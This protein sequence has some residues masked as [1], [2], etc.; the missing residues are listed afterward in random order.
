MILLC[1]VAGAMAQAP[2]FE[3]LGP[4]VSDR[5]TGLV[6]Q[7]CSVGMVWREGRCTG[8][9]QVF[10]WDEARGLGRDGWRLPEIDE[11]VS[12]VNREKSR[13]GEFPVTDVAAFPDLAGRRGDPLTYWSNTL[14]KGCMLGD[15][16]GFAVAFNVSFKGDLL[17]FTRKVP[18]FVRLVRNGARKAATASAPVKS[19]TADGRF[20][21]DGGVA[22]DRKTGL[23]WQRCL[24]GQ[25]WQAGRG[26]TGIR[27]RLTQDEAFAAE[28][29]GWRLPTKAELLTLID[30]D[31]KSAP[32][33]NAEAFPVTLPAYSD[34]RTRDPYPTGG[35]MFCVNFSIAYHNNCSRTYPIPVRLVSDAR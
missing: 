29:R 13:R 6:W 21:I 24:V 5:Q 35:H 2:R 14:A 27:V 19:V 22:R 9:P 3:A 1:M 30:R 12:L 10:T 16:C 25:D 26:C 32:M 34:L 7:R 15:V 18:L 20:E 33:V 28:G 4:E 8:S 31:R 17:N 23:R 11:L